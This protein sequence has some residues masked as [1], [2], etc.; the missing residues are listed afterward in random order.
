MNVNKY[1]TKFKH[2]LYIFR[3]NLDKI[4]AHFRHTLDTI[5]V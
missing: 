4:Q 2:S 1:E 3:Q 5:K